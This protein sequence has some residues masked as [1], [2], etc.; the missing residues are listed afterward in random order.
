MKI[1]ALPIFFLWIFIL[2]Y[3]IAQEMDT[4]ENS[5]MNLSG[6]KIKSCKI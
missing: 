5:I 3:D 6:V 2:S 1:K 4:H